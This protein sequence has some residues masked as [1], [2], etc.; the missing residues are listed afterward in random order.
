MDG[1]V[2]NYDSVPNE[3]ADDDPRWDMLPDIKPAVVAAIRVFL[4]GGTKHGKD[5]WRRYDA[6]AHIRAAHRHLNREAVLDGETGLPHLHH[7]LARLMLA[8][9]VD[10]EEKIDTIG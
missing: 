3:F 2:P 7:A 5:G 10:E 1:E 6:A 8:V 9:L 4:A